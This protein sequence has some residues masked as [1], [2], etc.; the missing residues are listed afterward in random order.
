MNRPYITIDGNE[1]AAYV[2]HKINEVI[3]IY[4]ITPSSP[5]GEFSDQWSSDGQPN[6]WGTIP[7]VVEMQ[8]EAGAA[9]A[10]HGALQGGSLATTFTSAQGLL[11]MIPNMYKIAGELTPCVLHVAA[12]SLAAHA[13]SIFGDH[14]DVMSVRGVGFAMLAS[15]SVQEVMDMA[16]ISQAASMESRVPFLHFF[17]GFRTSHEVAKVE[18]LAKEDLQAMISDELVQAHRKRGLTPDRPMLRGTAQNPDVYFQ[19]RETVNPFYLAVPTIVQNAMDKFAGLVGRKYEL[20]QYSGAP[21]AERV[22]ILMGSGAEVAEEAVEVMVE[23][24]QKVGL[25]KVRLYRPFSAEHFLQALPATT[26]SIAVLDRTKEPGCLGEPMY[27]DVLTVLAEAQASGTLKFKSMPKVI[28]GRYGLS[29]KEFTP[30]MVKGI[31]DELG[32]AKSKNHF[33]VGIVDDVTHTSIDYDPQFSTEHAKTVRALFYGLGADGTVGANKNSIKII[34]EDTDFYA[35]GYFVY[36]SK[37]SGSITTSHLRFGP[38]PLKSSYLISRANFVA[39]H[40]FSFLERIDMLRYADQGAVF[41]LNSPFPADQV[42]DEMPR[43]VQQQIIDKKLKFYV[44]DGYTVAKETGMG[45]RVNTIMQTCFFAISGVLPKEEAI[46]AIKHSIE[47]TYGKRGESVVAKNFAAVDAALAQ[48][49]EVKVP[50]TASS[51]KAVRLA[52]PAQAP[53]FVQNVLAP[54]I[55]GNGDDLPVSALPVDGTFPTGTAQWEKR[56]IAL[57]IPEWDEKICIQCGKCVLVCPHAVIRAKVYDSGLLKDAPATFKSK[58]AMW[59][60][61][62]G[63]KYTLQV[64]PEDCTGCALCIEACPAKSKTEPKHRAINMVPQIPLREQEARNWDF[65]LG[66]PEVD[67]SALSLTQVKD[68]QLLQPL[69]EFSGACS[70]CGETPYIKLMSQLFGDRTMVGNA[71]GCTSIYGGNLPTT[72]YTFNKDGRGIAWSNSLFEDAAEFAMGFRLAYDKQTEYARELLV[73]LGGQLPEA[74][75]KALLTADQSGEK[76]IREQ[77][78]R[79]VELKQ[80]LQGIK[81]AEGKDLLSLAD[82]LV[83][84]AVW[85]VGGDGWAYDIGYGGLDHVVA[86]G[87]NVNILVLD[88]EVYSNTGGQMSKAT[89]MGAV[90]KFAAAGKPRPKKDLAM[91]AVNY[92]TAYVARIAM[93]QSD[94]QTVKAFLEA[95]AYD[96]PSIIIAY[97]H[98]IAHGYDLVHGL[99]QQ[100]L[101]VQSGHWPLFRYNPMLAEGGKNPFVL[102]SKAPTVPLEKYI[103]NETRYTMLRQAHPDHAVALLKGA[104]A[105]VNERWRLY[106]YLAAMP[107][108]APKNEA[109]PEDG[110]P[111]S[112][113]AAND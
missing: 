81:T 60:N 40:Q 93:G 62:S 5:M 68:V 53:E 94:M 6:I 83:K 22:I 96:G 30:A 104:Q 108:P 73:R 4:P 41:L 71:T 32:K 102:D 74:L 106:E 110:K 84:K 20:F 80:K 52:V 69:F 109:K 1:A 61:F 65:F 23:K 103:Y 9:G 10:L 16:L 58:D 100:K 57:E 13:L 28:G 25:I 34:G 18:A 46:E 88:T 55:L 77:R 33:T 17:D 113:G 87:R 107:G 19:G 54:M 24:G 39:C 12:R 70:G 98:C 31:F 47:K 15:N 111:L 67:R 95:E 76:G 7:Q 89:P 14:Q 105:E 66:L 11:L 82:A 86:S 45:S 49:H 92:G 63:S 97:S 43:K 38:K 79:V 75:V 78:V 26:K 59:K 50:A 21:D 29:S 44:I 35:Q 90:A 8:S 99:D 27:Q 85:A 64:A 72:P 42:W 2:A 36:D 112:K 91:M 101:A 3:A 48:L 56:N 51:S 37:K